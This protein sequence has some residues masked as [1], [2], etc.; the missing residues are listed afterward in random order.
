MNKTS[1]SAASVELLSGSNPD[2][3]VAAL[4]S[5]TFTETG[6]KHATEVHNAKVN[7]LSSDLKIQAA[8]S[9]LDNSEACILVAKKLRKLAKLLDLS[10]VGK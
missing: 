4:L 8:E 6:T 10:I 1:Q 3:L 5:I 9:L 2:A 7:V